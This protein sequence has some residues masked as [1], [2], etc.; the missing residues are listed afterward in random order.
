MV[1][2]EA[3][4]D[5]N[6]RNRML[7]LEV[8]EMQVCADCGYHES[9]LAD[10]TNVIMPELRYCPVCAG[11]DTYARVLHEQDEEWASQH[12]D[13]AP[14]VRRPADGRRMVMRHLSPAEADAE[15][16]RRQR[17]GGEPGGNTPREG[18]S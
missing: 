12:K 14:K 6:E 15:R 13:A 16:Q 7:A 10:R 2:R 1:T 4:W 9:V 11:G 3:E 5:R 17:K 8:Y 18:R